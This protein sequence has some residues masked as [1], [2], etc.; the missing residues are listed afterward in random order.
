[1]STTAA[2]PPTIPPDSA[3][4]LVPG[5][6]LGKADEAVGFAG[7]DVAPEPEGPVL[8]AASLVNQALTNSLLQD[9]GYVPFC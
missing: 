9:S 4:F 7:A 8:F 3:P 6:P 5:E 2:T 1:M